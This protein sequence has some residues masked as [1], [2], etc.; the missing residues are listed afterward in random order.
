MK[1]ESLP[2][3]LRRGRRH[4]PFCGETP[5]RPLVGPSS[6]AIFKGRDARE[7]EGARIRF[8]FPHS[9]A[10][11]KGRV[12]ID[13]DGS[14]LNVTTGKFLIIDNNGMAGPLNPVVFP[15]QV[16]NVLRVRAT[17]W[18]GCRSFSPLWVHCLATG[19]KRQLFTGYSGAG[20]AYTRGEFLD[21]NLTV[22]L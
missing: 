15:G 13:D 6:G 5:Q 7:G 14:I 2:P 8:L 19:A 10:F 12:T 16:G 17:D 4:T 3:G 1:G 11:R 22:E 21:M 20:C 18:G 9:H